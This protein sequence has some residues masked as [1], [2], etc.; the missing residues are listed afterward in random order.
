MLA[1]AAN[2]TPNRAASAVKPAMLKITSPYSSIKCLI[3]AFLST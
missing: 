3:A 1:P 2:K